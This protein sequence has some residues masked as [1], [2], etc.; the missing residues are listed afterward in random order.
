MPYRA[1]LILMTLFAG[2]A[3]A[4]EDNVPEE[5]IQVS[6]QITDLRCVDPSLNQ[7]NIGNE[8]RQGIDFLDAL[9]YRDA[10]ATLGRA[11]NA[12]PCVTEVVNTDTLARLF[13]YQGIA[14]YNQDDRINTELFFRLALAVDLALPWDTDY[15]PDPQ[16]IFLTVKTELV[17]S[18]VATDLSFDLRNNQLRELHINGVSYDPMMRGSIRVCPGL[19]LIQ[20]THDEGVLTRM[21]ESG[22]DPV[23]LR[24][25]RVPGIYIPDD[26]SSYPKHG[27][28]TIMPA[29]YSMAH[30]ARYYNAHLR[31]DIRIVAGLEAQVG[32]G[33]LTNTFEDDDGINWTALMPYAM[34]GARYHFVRDKPAQPYL[35]GAFLISFWENGGSRT[36]SPGIC[37]NGG[38][39][40]HLTRVFYLNFDSLIGYSHNLWLSLAGGVGFRF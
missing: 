15:P 3:L 2:T 20:V 36:S 22:Q 7:L 10:T 16:Q 26:K 21:I 37:F 29:G 32:A 8:L 12:L 31:L 34:V 4:N 23:E 28:L 17:G 35:G 6:G 25:L 24:G 40:V 14:Y 38:F 1:I 33:L 27:G 13:F 39:N 18:S 19:H 5:S 30:K 9:N 11:I